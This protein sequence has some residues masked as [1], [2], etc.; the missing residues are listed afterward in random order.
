MDLG[1][2]KICDLNIRITGGTL[3]RLFS[4]FRAPDQNAQPIC[5]IS[6]AQETVQHGVRCMTPAHPVSHVFGLGS[7]RG[8]VL[9]SDDT[10]EHSTAI[11]DG[12]EYREAMD[13]LLPAV[14]SRLAFFRTVFAH[15]SL[16]DTKDCGGVLFLGPSGVGKTTQA[17]LWRQYR[18]ADILSGDKA[19]LTLNESGDG[20]TAHCSPWKGNS[21]FCI[22]RS[23][24]LGG[25]VVLE[26]AE[27]NTIRRLDEMEVLAEYLSHLFLPAWDSRC[28]DMVMDMIG[29]MIPLVP[30]Y[31]LACRPDEDAVALTRRTLFGKD[32]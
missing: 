13:V 26:Q 9:M 20:V 23:V 27:T 5:S 28:T 7:E 6:E 8:A 17:K 18:G 25:I 1:L 3:C 15:A 32:E 4:D 21:G 16:I 31:R 24:P 22:N 19:F 29:G 12:L 30:M 11:I 14:C 10:Y 2:F